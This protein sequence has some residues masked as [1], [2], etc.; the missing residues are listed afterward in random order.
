MNTMQQIPDRTALPI[1][2][3]NP[4]PKWPAGYFE[5][6]EEAGMLEKP[7]VVVVFGV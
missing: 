6:L 5:V 7:I 2:P 1:A 3:F 4:N